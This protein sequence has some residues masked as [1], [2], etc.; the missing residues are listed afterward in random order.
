M[1]HNDIITGVLKEASR[2][3]YYLLSKGYPERGALK[4]VGDRYRLTRDQRSL[5]YRGISSAEASEM[6]RRRLVKLAPDMHLVID[7]YNVLFTILNYRLGRMVFI[8]TDGILRD[9]GSLHGKLRDDRLFHECIEDLFTTIMPFHPLQTDIF[10]DSPVSSSPRHHNAI[11]QHLSDS[12][13]SGTCKLVHSADQEIKSFN[14][15]ILSTSDTVLIEKTT[16][17]VTD[18]ARLVLEDT[19]SAKLFRIRTLLDTL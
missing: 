16:M 8:S 1:K 5:L 15:G 11:I 6:R 14:T 3:Y 13:I 12:G 17:P 7:G 9:A 19:Y 18:L 2:D 4:M 10:L